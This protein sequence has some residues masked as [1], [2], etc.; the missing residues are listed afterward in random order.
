M[1]MMISRTYDRQAGRG[2]AAAAAS[3]P[4][5]IVLV[6]CPLLVLSS[7]STRCP[8]RCSARVAPPGRSG[9]RP[10][11]CPP[12]GLTRTPQLTVMDCLLSA[13]I[14]RESRKIWREVKRMAGNHSSHSNTPI[15]VG[16]TIFCGWRFRTTSATS[17][18]EKV[19]S[20]CT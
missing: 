12:Q 17:A 19:I 2:C 4:T 13:S 5:D 14:S 7:S 11:H 8:T 20:G 16:S 10:D 6:P 1:R 18:S 3:W 15:H 9:H